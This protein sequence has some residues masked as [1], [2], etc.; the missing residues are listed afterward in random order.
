MKKKIV[1]L[2]FSL[3]IAL[4]V[5]KFLW[6]GEK[7]LNDGLY[8]GPIEQHQR[9][10]LTENF[11]IRPDGLS[12]A[13]AILK[14]A[15]GS[16]EIKFY[17]KHAPKTVKR[18]VKLIQSEYYDGLIFH[19]VIPNFVIQTGDPSKTGSGGSGQTIMAEFN[20]LPH[21]KGTV[22][23]ARSKEIHSADSQFYIALSSLP[24]LDEKY[25]VFG[26]VTKGTDILSK[27]KRGDKIIS[28]SFH[29]SL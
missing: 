8:T 9:A 17:P 20:K 13:T 18:I 27:I 4:I 10:L 6:N 16:I 28:F 11:P 19:R 26:Q 14:T 25:T 3:S 29:H 5:L 22:A 1:F 2:F 21:I 23:M 7:Y 24:H 15:Y 12:K